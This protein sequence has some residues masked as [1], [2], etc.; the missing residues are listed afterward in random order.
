[1]PV[2]HI[3]RPTSIEQL[4]KRAKALLRGYREG[5]DEAL[6]LFAEFMSPPPMRSEAQLADAQLV[7]A[8]RH[9]FPG[10]PRMK[11]G[12]ELFNAICADDVKE[13]FALMAAHPHLRTERV[14]GVTSNWGP[15][16]A[17]AAQVNARQ[18]VSALLKAGG[19]DL[20]AGL[21]RAVLHGRSRMAREI[22][23]AGARV[24]PD[25]VMGP[26]ETLNAKGLK[27]VLGLGAPLD[28]GRGNR[29][30]PLGLVLETY[31][32]WPEGKHG[33]LEI[34]SD[35][36]ELPDTPVM[37][38]H[39]GRIDLL[40]AHLARDPGMLRRTF[41]HRDI[42]PLECG[43]SADETLG[44]HGTPLAG[45]TLLHMAADFDELAIARWL[46]KNGADVNAR[47][48]VDADGFGGHT[49]LF[50]VVVSQSWRCGR[51]RDGKFARLLLK[52]G[53]DVSLRASVRKGF[54]F[55]DDEA[56]REYRDV[57]ALEYGRRFHERAWLS[58]VAM[59]EIE[60]VLSTSHPR[61]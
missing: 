15:P 22:L 23:R 34:L 43:C 28:D 33:C 57:T 44:L 54:R 29:L 25:E 31:S 12:I 48:E 20:E 39:R 26:C 16:L 52:A 36:V 6:K 58:S 3:L 13:V 11:Q 49:P 47:A 18:V 1:M 10:W 8:R 60:R 32:R 5:E 41:S 40:E 14:T 17:C 61:A 53:A 42:Y 21:G 50:N 27:F 4:R 46:L 56:V 55:V 9:D 2:T 7:L 51:Q 19:Q 37:A 38:L 45:T 24:A 30:A 35:H 59:G